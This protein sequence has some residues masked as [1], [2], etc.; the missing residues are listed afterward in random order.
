MAA[1]AADAPPGA[2]RPA[3]NGTLTLVF[4][5]HALT[6]STT[7]CG[8]GRTVPPTN[9]FHK[10]GTAETSV[11]PNVIAITSMRNIHMPATRKYHVGTVMETR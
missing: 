6:Y 1:P 3:P 7:F 11:G 8:V 2:V 10:P 4:G 9:S 5:S